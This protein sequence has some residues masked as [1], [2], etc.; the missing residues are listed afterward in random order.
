MN[1]LKKIVIITSLCCSLAVTLESCN[2]IQ[3]SDKKRWPSRLMVIKDGDKT[4]SLCCEFSE[5]FDGGVR[6][7]LVQD[8]ISITRTSQAIC[9]LDENNKAGLI[10][11]TDHIGGGVF[12]NGKE[13][14]PFSTGRNGSIIS[15]E[16]VNEVIIDGFSAKDIKLQTSGVIHE[17]LRVIIIGDDKSINGVSPR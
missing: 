17:K 9:H 13:L 7:F 16:G 5:Q 15:S 4:Y 12:L 6:W 2:R 10:W 8:N 14:N 3:N 11:S 1:F